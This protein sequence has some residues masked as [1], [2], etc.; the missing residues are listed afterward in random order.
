[1]ATKL[2]E[3]VQARTPALLRTAFLLT[4]DADA[5]QDLLQSALERVHRRH[6]R[7][8]SALEAYLRATMATLASNSRRRRWHHE[9]LH[10]VLPEFPAAGQDSDGR[11]AMLAALRQLTPEQ[12]VVLVLRFYEDLTEVQTAHEL[13][14]AVG[15]VKS[16]TARALAALRESHLLTEEPR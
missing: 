4:G 5:A 15:T 7:D 6:L 8:P 2:D 16:R 14:I 13:G 11:L 12:R 9:H 3:L 1:V 10:A